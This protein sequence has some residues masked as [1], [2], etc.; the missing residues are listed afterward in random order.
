[1][2]LFF[3]FA[4]V[5][6]SPRPRPRARCER[7]GSWEA[8]G[9]CSNGGLSRL[10]DR[11]R[12]SSKGGGGTSGP[13]RGWTRSPSGGTPRSGAVATIIDTIMSNIW[14]GNHRGQ[15]IRKGIG[16]RGWMDRSMGKKDDGWY[17]LTAPLA[18]LGPPRTMMAGIGAC[19]MVDDITLLGTKNQMRGKV[20]GTDDNTRLI[21]I[22]TTRKKV[23]RLI[24]S[25]RNSDI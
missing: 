15:M 9:R 22:P 24:V 1:M 5:S 8:S 13:V 25:R 7:P 20:G 10:T 14:G 16:A 12:I 11:A 3:I 6:S 18:W 19:V 21:G 2:H 4:L 17:D 23:S